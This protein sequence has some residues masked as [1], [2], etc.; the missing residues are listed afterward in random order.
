MDIFDIIGPVMVGPSSSHTAGAVRIGYVGQK[1]LAEPVVKAQ[2]GLYG[3]FGL[4]ERGMGTDRALAAGL[5]GWEPEDERIPR[6]L[7][8]A[9]QAG[10]ELSFYQADLKDAHPNTAVI[11]MTGAGGR[12]LEVIAASIG[13]GRIRICEVDGLTVNVCGEYP[14]LIVH[15]LD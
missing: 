1:L 11:H 6:S 2:I 10:V 12:E 13:G 15:N 4:P 9:E 8:I 5:M 7:E 3:S 14:T